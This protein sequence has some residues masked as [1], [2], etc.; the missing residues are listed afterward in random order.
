MANP[1][2]KMLAHADHLEAPEKGPPWIVLWDTAVR[3]DGNWST[4][5]TQSEAAAL[6][7][8]AHFVKLGFVVHAIKDPSGAV[9]MDAARITD[10]F[11]AGDGATS[12]LARERP[13]LSDEEA[14]RVVVRGLAGG[15]QAMP[16]R[17]LPAA[18]LRA[19]VLPRGLSHADFERAVSFAKD[20]AWIS[21]ADGILTLTQAGYAVATA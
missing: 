13:V 6:E 3:P 17:M 8:A 10:R 14:A 5:R 21:D 19:Q 11:R 9:I 20:H 4:V 12:K 15:P 7:R 2:R 18:A 16:G 1:H